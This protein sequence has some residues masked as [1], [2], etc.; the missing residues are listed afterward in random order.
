MPDR[1][2]VLG[3]RVGTEISPVHDKRFRNELLREANDPKVR[4]GLGLEE[5]IIQLED[6]VGINMPFDY[7]LRLN[8][9]LEA[10]LRWQQV[11]HPN[12]LNAIFFGFDPG[13]SPENTPP[14][15]SAL[16]VIESSSRLIDRGE[17]QVVTATDLDISGIIRDTASGIHIVSLRY[18]LQEGGDLAQSLIS[19]SSAYKKDEYYGGGDVTVSQHIP[20]SRF[21][22]GFPS[23]YPVITDQM[24]EAAGHEQFT[25]ATFT[26]SMDPQNFGTRP[27]FTNHRFYERLETAGSPGSRTLGP[28]IEG[29]GETGSIV[30]FDWKVEYPN[31]V[32][33][34]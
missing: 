3:L 12:A 32:A 27:R 4:I 19:L 16:T 33:K 22:M 13:K 21:I 2:P 7:L 24:R 14:F 30:T 20:N 6:Q 10:E 5:I 25:E 8:Q 34:S 11:Y 18:D 28:G 29:W 15:Q 31:S 23:I 1:R 17:K 26:G 9:P